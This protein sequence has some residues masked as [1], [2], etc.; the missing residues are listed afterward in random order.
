MHHRHSKHYSAKLPILL[1]FTA[2][3]IAISLIIPVLLGTGR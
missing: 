3:D 1:V 2:A